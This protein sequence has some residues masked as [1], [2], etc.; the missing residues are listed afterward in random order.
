MKEA[1]TRL[2]IAVIL[3]VNAVLT[4]KGYNP[5]PFNENAVTEAITQLF[6]AAGVVWVWWKNNNVTHEAREAQEYL[7]W[8]K[9]DDNEREVGDEL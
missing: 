5:I 9:S 8:L 3:L 1:I 2:V 4:A 7:N 6:A